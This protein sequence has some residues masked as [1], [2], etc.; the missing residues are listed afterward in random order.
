[1]KACPWTPL[2]IAQLHGAHHEL[3]CVKAM[4]Q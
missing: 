3:L 1:M 4:L 2:E